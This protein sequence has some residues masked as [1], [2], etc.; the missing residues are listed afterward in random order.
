[1]QRLIFSTPLSLK[2]SLDLPI[3]RR[4]FGSTL[5][6]PLRF[7]SGKTESS[8]RAATELSRV[9]SLVNGC[10]YNH[11]LVV[12]QPPE[13]Y[14][15]RQEIIQYYVTTLAMALGSEKAAKES[16]YSVST[17]YYYA[18]SCKITENVT[19][20]IKSLPRVKWV[21]PDSYLS[22]CESGYGGEPCV[23]GEVVPYEEKYHAEWLR[24]AYDD[25]SK[26]ITSSRKPRRKRRG[27]RNPC[28]TTD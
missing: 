28:A 16:I 2:A 19:H 27:S 9:D 21:L 12:M 26:E 8:N 1:M 20:K 25:E 4:H 13:N 5:H 3:F 15:Q 11:W 10:D 7:F 24:D 6:Y 17:K 14:P 18:F 23:D 22:P